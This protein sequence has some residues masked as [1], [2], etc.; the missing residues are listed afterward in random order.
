M[1]KIKIVLVICLTLGLAACQKPNEEISSAE[2]ATTQDNTSSSA[3][4]AFTQSDEKIGH[5]L[6]QLDAPNISIDDKTKIL[7]QDYPNE[8]KKHYM[9]AMLQ[10]A[11]Q[12][13]T[14]EKMLNDLQISIDYYR[15]KLNIRCT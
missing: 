10:L 5:Y 4:I 2:A 14:Q 1:L 15:E 8:Y 3:Q 13:Y 12:D 9:P 11:S 6:D 7:C